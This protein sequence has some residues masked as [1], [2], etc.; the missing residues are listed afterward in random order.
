MKAAETNGN[1]GEVRERIQKLVGAE[2]AGGFVSTIL[3]RE[4]GL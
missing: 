4:L 3:G 2:K 1:A